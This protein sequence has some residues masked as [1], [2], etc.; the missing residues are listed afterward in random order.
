MY[1]KEEIQSIKR[2][3]HFDRI[4]EEIKDMTFLPYANA[5]V[6]SG[7][8]GIY[9]VDMGMFLIHRLFPKID[10]RYMYL[11]HFLEHLPLK[12]DPYRIDDSRDNQRIEGLTSRVRYD[13]D[14]I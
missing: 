14:R 3:I 4:N 10:R 11:E 5:L 12:V 7:Q 13:F 9:L 1:R 2:L 6:A 8:T